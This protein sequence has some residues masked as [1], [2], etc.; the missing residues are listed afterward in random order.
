MS[1]TGPASRSP[2]E[3]AVGAAAPH[4]TTIL[5]KGVPN[6]SAGDEPTRVSDR[7]S[8]GSAA[9]IALR[10]AQIEGYVLQDEVH[11]GGQGVVYRALQLGTKREVA[12]KVL[13]EGPFASDTA[14]RRFEREVELAASLRHPSIVTI[15][16]SG[17]SFGRYYF[18]MEFIDGLRL[19]RYLAKNRCTLTDTLRLFEKI[20]AAVAFAHLRGVIHR[21]LKPSNVLV[22]ADGQPHVLD[23][24]LAKPVHRVDSF[25]TTVAMLSTTGQI[26]GT[27]AYMSPEQSTGSQD[28]DV[29]SDVYSLGV[30]LYE[31]LLGQLPYSVEGPLGEVLTRIG[32]QD[33]IRPRSIRDRSR[34]GRQINDELETILLKTLEKSPVMRYQGA[35]DL[36]RDVRHLLDGEAIEAK[37]ASGLYLFKKLLSRYR[38]QAV[39][40]G[41]ALI[42][43]I[44]FVVLLAI[45]LSGER[46]A[47]RSAEEQRS[48]ADVREREARAAQAR[49]VEAREDAE[50]RTI[51]A[52]RAER[53]L[54]RALARTKIQQGDLARERG[55]L[56]EARASYWDAFDDAAGGGARWALRQY[57]VQT[58]DNGATLLARQRFG[59]TALSRDGAL[60]AVCESP[61]SIVIRSLPD[62]VCAGW[63][64]TPGAVA[65]ARLEPSG[66]LAAAGA[67]WARLWG[68]GELQP[69]VALELPE[70]VVPLAA[71]ACSNGQTLV[72]ACERDGQLVLFSRTRASDIHIAPSNV[73]L[74]GPGDY[75]AA[76]NQIALPVSNWLMLVGVGADGDISQERL[77]L[78]QGT[79][80]RAARFVSDTSVAVLSDAVFQTNLSGSERGRWTKLTDVAAE[81]E[82][83]D[84]IPE[85]S[86]VLL[87]TSDGRLAIHRFGSVESSWRATLGGLHLLQ[88]DAT[89]GGLVTLDDNGAL[90]RWVFPGAREQRRVVMRRAPI[91]WASSPDGDEML[92][93]DSAGRV[94]QYSAERMDRPIIRQPPGLLRRLTGLEAADISLAMS[95]GGRRAAIRAGDSVRILDLQEGDGRTYQWRN[96]RMSQLA[97]ID[98][99]HDG[100]LVAYLAQSPAGDRQRVGFWHSA[101]RTPR[102]HQTPSDESPDRYEPYD[103][104]GASVRG[105]TFVPRSTRLLVARSNGQLFLLEPRQIDAAP[106]ASQPGPPIP[107][108]ELDSPVETM[109]CDRAGRLVAVA[110]EDYTVRVL[111]LPD[112]ETLHRLPIGR[113]ARTLA[114]SRKGDVL[115]VRNDTS[116]VL[117]EVATGERV[118]SWPMP[119]GDGPALALWTRGDESLVMN[120]GD[121]VYEY[122]FSAADELIEQN[123]AFARQAE[124]AER[125]AENDPAGAWVLTQHLPDEQFRLQR[126]IRESIVESALR[127]P[128]QALNRHW[129][130]EVAGDAPPRT[131]LR[132]AHAAYD[133]EQFDVAL[134]LFRRGYSAAGGPVDAASLMRLAD[135]EFLAE[136]YAVAARGYERASLAPDADPARGPTVAVLRIAALV[137]ADRLDEAR[138]LTIRLRDTASDRVPAAGARLAAASTSARNIA[139]YLV[140]FESESFLLSGVEGLVST[141]AD[142]SLEF[143]DDLHFF[144]AEMARK[145]GELDDAKVQYQ[146]CI[147]LS[148]DRWPANWS[149]FRIAQLRAKS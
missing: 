93:A 80:P 1:G 149:R 118:A 71:F 117:F 29:R 41:S 54:R 129:L 34:F 99:S 47:R 14:R 6:S 60:A 25:E 90:T 9:Q 49:E 134:E 64:R 115:S 106:P 62:Q 32:K 116:V 145:R 140:G 24:G 2:G 44:A 103:F 43:L 36:G 3:D 126:A 119:A 147:D 37:R 52:I 111:S 78:P 20:C 58:P 46:D 84:V 16:D 67:G 27:V 19:D 55:D 30:M 63:V 136:Q 7:G 65:A 48:R 53:D 69:R 105:L 83:F 35:A 143:R 138:Q 22:D 74:T 82:L 121:V 72:V 128:R 91:A 28:A 146:R 132:L 133:G 79:R 122:R 59:P 135:C 4:D 70:D 114:F 31:A 18:A 123:R 127:R 137:L 56:S 73:A 108:L 12:L 120:E 75:S 45:A 125:L 112:G 139:R 5:P 102:N 97:H 50:A 100:E 8:G 76:L 85:R 104:V 110:C 131:L 40:A 88:R 81:W 96:P 38:L 89:G 61:E 109:A 11:R 42:M 23:F 51:E 141:F 33:P 95:D 17:V 39:I 57:Y 94:V 15:L 101:S 21:D 26:L 142:A 92:L 68:P 113:R 77:A 148:R 87:G 107:W 130:D 66:M 98:L 144:S 124:I 13:L 86:A 10:G